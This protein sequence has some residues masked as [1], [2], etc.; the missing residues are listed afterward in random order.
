MVFLANCLGENSVCPSF[1]VIYSMIT[2]YSLQNIVNNKRYVGATR[3]FEKRQQDHIR[4]LNKGEHHSWKLQRDYDSFGETSFVFE[5]L[6]IVDDNLQV[7]REQFYID[8][9]DAIKNGYNASCALKIGDRLEKKK[10]KK[11]AEVPKTFIVFDISYQTMAEMLQT[12]PGNMRLRECRGE[13]D[14][15]NLES[16]ILFLAANIILRENRKLPAGTNNQQMSD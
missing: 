16:V 4:L 8:N 11:Y 12:S 5:I 3:N 15:K 6:E 10:R 13:F 9:F 1:G 7:Q 14:I 2:I